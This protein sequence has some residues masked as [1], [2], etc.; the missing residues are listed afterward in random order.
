M[1]AQSE[2]QQQQQ[3][4]HPDGKAPEA[5]LTPRSLAASLAG[6]RTDAAALALLLALTAALAVG[7]ALQ[8]DHSW[9]R[10]VWVSCLLGPA[11]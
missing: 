11:G 10:T 7:T 5:A 2:D 3:Q 6:Y 4:Q 8:R 1:K 9:L